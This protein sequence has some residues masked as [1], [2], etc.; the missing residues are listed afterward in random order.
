MFFMFSIS[1]CVSIRNGDLS[2]MG[3]I[4]TSQWLELLSLARSS[5]NFEPQIPFEVVDG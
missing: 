1:G 3:M 2:V 4:E 5:K